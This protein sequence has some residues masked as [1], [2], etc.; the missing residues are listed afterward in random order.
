MKQSKDGP[1]CVRWVS[2]PR[3]QYVFESDKGLLASLN[4]KFPLY[5]GGDSMH[6]QCVCAYVMCVLICVWCVYVHAE[7]RGPLQLSVLTFHLFEIGSL[8][9]CYTLWVRLASLWASGSSPVSTFHPVATA[10]GLLT[11][12]P[13]HLLGKYFTH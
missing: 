10:L 3:T 1:R 2:F 4:P 12:R 8:Y 13:S 5:A 7:V 9:C 6:V 11:L